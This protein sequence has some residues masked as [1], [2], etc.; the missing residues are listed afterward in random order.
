MSPHL[1]C[2]PSVRTVM[3]LFTVE[4]LGS[5]LPCSILAMCA[6]ET[7]ASSAKRF[8]VKH[9]SVLSRLIML[10]VTAMPQ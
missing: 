4:S 5:T 3:I 2:L 9:A 7:P 10:P 6:C 1:F 8:W